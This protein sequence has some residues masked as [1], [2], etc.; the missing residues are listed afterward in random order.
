M[1]VPEYRRN[2]QYLATGYYDRFYLDP[3]SSSSRG[4]TEPETPWYHRETNGVVAIRQPP[5]PIARE[6][7]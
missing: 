2:L 6:L 5:N 1:A 7:V 4:A 3:A